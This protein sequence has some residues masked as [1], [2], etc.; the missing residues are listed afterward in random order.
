MYEVANLGLS[1][2]TAL[3]RSG[4]FRATES[5]VMEAMAHPGGALTKVMS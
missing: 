1:F 3:T 2:G 4:I 5:F